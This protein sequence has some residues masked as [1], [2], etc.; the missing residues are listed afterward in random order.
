[1]TWGLCHFIN[2]G[3]WGKQYSIIARFDCDLSLDVDDASMKNT[4]VWHSPDVYFKQ[5]LSAA[6][7][8]R[9]Q[10]ENDKRLTSE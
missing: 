9:I 3:T 5:G 1:V 2:A 6:Q 8:K 7:R 4:G 10:A